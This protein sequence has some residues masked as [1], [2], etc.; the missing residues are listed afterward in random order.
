MLVARVSILAFLTTLAFSASV[1][2]QRQENVQDLDSP[3]P[4]RVT[5]PSS[6]RSPSPS[7]PLLV[8]CD[9]NVY[10]RNLNVASCR[11]VFSHMP[12][13]DAQVT[14]AERHSGIP[15]DIPL[16]WRVMSSK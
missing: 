9:G 1:V 6:L 5:S 14:F 3:L 12:R 15:H 13:G 11:D 7:S 8:H 2:V 4:S 10:G 16:P